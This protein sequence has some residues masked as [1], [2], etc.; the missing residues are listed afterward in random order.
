MT[1]I[2]TKCKWGKPIDD[3]NK[4][5]RGP[6]GYNRVC[7]KCKN[8]EKFKTRKRKKNGGQPGSIYP[9]YGVGT[10][11]YARNAYF[12]SVY[13]ITLIEYNKLLIDQD[14][15][16]AI[17]KT[18][19]SL[20]SKNLGVDHDHITGQVRGLLCFKCNAAIGKLNDDIQLL[21]NAM[22]Y[23]YRYHKK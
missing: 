18:P 17:C 1:R 14:Y 23:L 22:I 16:C 3:F 12:I 15:A 9:Q 5:K 7:R 13:G 8:K 20:L 19:Q 10:K 4:Q 21:G 6:D 2:C 11:E